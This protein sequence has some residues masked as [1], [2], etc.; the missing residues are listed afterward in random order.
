MSRRSPRDH[1]G[2]KAAAE[3][4]KREQLETDPDIVWFLTECG[5]DALARATAEA[6]LFG[7]GL[8]IAD[9]VACECPTPPRMGTGLIPVRI[10]DEEVVW[11]RRRA[12]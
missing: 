12:S 5:Q 2:V 9:V 1:A 10:S 6:W 3:L 4:A 8:T 11:E 7:S